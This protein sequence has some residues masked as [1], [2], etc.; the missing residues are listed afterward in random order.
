MLAP[1]EP[2]P[3]LVEDPTPW[4]DPH[5]VFSYQICDT[6]GMN[7]ACQAWGAVKTIQQTGASAPSDRRDDVGLRLEPGVPTHDLARTFRAAGAL[8]D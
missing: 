1:G 2:Y 6:Y 5:L 8:I 7:V 4:A 3:I